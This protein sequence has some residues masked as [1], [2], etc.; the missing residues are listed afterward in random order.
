MSKEI[1]KI[2]LKMEELLSDLPSSFRGKNHGF[3]LCAKEH[4]RPVHLDPSQTMKWILS[5]TARDRHP[6]F[7]ILWNAVCANGGRK[8]CPC[9]FPMCF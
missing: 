3:S 2:L 4:G 6:D 7:P 5:Y 1:P 8:P 9:P